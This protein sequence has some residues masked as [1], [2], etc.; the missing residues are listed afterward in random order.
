MLLRTQNTLSC[1]SCGRT[2]SSTACKWLKP[3]SN[4]P[5]PACA[6]NKDKPLGIVHA[7][8]RDF[9]SNGLASIGAVAA[10]DAMKVHWG[11]H[12]AEGHSPNIVLKDID[13]LKAQ[14][15]VMQAEISKR[16]GALVATAEETADA[17]A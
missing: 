1:S 13:E 5:Q 7:V 17:G 4:C 12:L 2:G 6:S 10:L 9:A 15:D 8:N 14:L 11:V 3:G 16:F